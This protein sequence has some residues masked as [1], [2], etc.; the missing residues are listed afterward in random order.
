MVKIKEEPYHL[1]E[2]EVIY[3]NASNENEQEDDG[4]YYDVGTIR[5]QVQRIWGPDI[6][7]KIER[8]NSDDENEQE[9]QVNSSDVGLVRNQVRLAWSEDEVEPK[10]ES[11]GIEQSLQPIIQMDRNFV[12]KNFRSKWIEQVELTFRRPSLKKSCQLCDNHLYFNSVK[13]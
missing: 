2:H 12:R 7:P 4:I 13:K 6:K 5:D 3:R 8:S 9:N 10:V 11:I 1:H